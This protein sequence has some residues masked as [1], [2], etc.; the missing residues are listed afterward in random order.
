MPYIQIHTTSSNSNGDWLFHDIEI[1]EDRLDW[2]EQARAEGRTNQALE[3][4][5]AE[6]WIKVNVLGL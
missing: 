5:I 3:Q 2:W 4:G 1:L 6:E